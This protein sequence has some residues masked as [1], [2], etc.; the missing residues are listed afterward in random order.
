MSRYIGQ[1][2]NLV[3]LKQEL[4]EYLDF[5]EKDGQEYSDHY[6]NVRSAYRRV[7]QMILYPNDIFV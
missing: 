7:K 2:E 6:D 4:L 3:E 5:L 1:N